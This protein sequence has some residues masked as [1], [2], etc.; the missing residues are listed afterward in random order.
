MILLK[1]LGEASL[2]KEEL[3]LDKKGCKKFGPCGVGRKALYLN[4]FYI[5]RMYYV[6]LSS[7]RRV[8]K[9]VAM[10]K[11]GFTGKG[12]FATIPYLVVQYDNGQE[13]QCNFKHEE[14]VDALLKYLH[15]K[16]PQIPCHSAEGEKRLRAKERVLAEKK[17]KLADASAKEE[18]RQLE[19]CRA[20]LE[21]RPALSREL[22]E[23]AKRKRAYDY[24]NPAYKWIALCIVLLGMAAVGYGVYALLTGAGFAVYFLLFG[25]AAIF[26]FSGANV[27]PTAKNNR[28]A[29]EARLQSA[30]EAMERYLRSYPDFL[31]PAYY[32][33]PDVCSRMIWI[34]AEH[35][36][37]SISEALEVLK[38]DLK[39]LTAD[40]EVEQEEYDEIVTIKPLFL[41]RDYM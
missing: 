37:D 10:S 8:F 7:V 20:Y 33:H 5:D 32:A 39:A 23:A 25:M 17:A 31:L 11:G 13:K 29:V 3:S 1:Q 38:K 34:L 18:I 2:E 21:K 36:A 22:S 24:S 6:K 12:M 41:V 15:E 28:R 40:V 16:H 30:T 4:S 19:N 14:Q 26:L 27:L 35:R 9:R